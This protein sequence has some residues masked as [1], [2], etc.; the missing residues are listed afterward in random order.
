MR[1]LK[2]LEVL[3][4]LESPNGFAHRLAQVTSDV[5]SI[6]LEQC[7]LVQATLEILSEECMKVPGIEYDQ[8][9]FTTSELTSKCPTD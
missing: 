8:Q 9:P 5:Y 1:P 6:K 3:S 2:S 4:L 7:N